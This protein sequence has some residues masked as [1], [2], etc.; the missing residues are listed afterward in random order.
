MKE[1]ARL[2]IV[3]VIIVLYNYFNKP[4]FNIEKDLSFLN[5]VIT[6]VLSMLTYIGL[7]FFF[8]RKHKR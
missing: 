4:L 2:L 8:K 5:V 6:F 7:E 3:F 1:W